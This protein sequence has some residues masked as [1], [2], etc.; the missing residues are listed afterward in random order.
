MGH[1][2]RVR[3][4]WVKCGNGARNQWEK[5]GRC[6]RELLPGQGAALANSASK[7][8][9]VGGARLELSAENERNVKKNYSVT[10]REKRIA[11]EWLQGR[12]GGYAR[13][14]LQTCRDVRPMRK[15]RAFRIRLGQSFLRERRRAWTSVGN[16]FH[17]PART[18]IGQ[19]R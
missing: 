6:F 8:C 13:R 4:E 5:L 19:Q 2:E 10:L 11:A 9:A 16:Y 7:Y 1:L 17:V 15:I 3:A 14:N 18:A 12:R